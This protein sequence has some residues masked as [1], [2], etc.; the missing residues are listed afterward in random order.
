MEQFAGNYTGP[1]WSN[2]IWQESVEFGDTDPK[3]ELDALS[4][5]HDS[6][7]AK[8][9]DNA[10][11]EAAD[12]IYEKEAKALVGRFPHLAGDLVLHGN[13]TWGQAKDA[14]FYSQLGLPGLIYFAGKNM[15]NA[16]KMIHGTYLQ[17]EQKEILDYFKTD[18][19]KNLQSFG[20]GVATLGKKNSVS[21]PEFVGKKGKIN[22]INVAPK[23]AVPE[24]KTGK[25]GVKMNQVTPEDKI[26]YQ[27]QKANAANIQH[28]KNSRG[29][30]MFQLNKRE[31]HLKGQ[32]GKVRV[33]PYFPEIVPDSKLKLT[34]EERE[35]RN[36][37]RL[38]MHLEVRRRPPP[39]N[40]VEAAMPY[41]HSKRY[42]FDLEYESEFQ[43]R[44]PAFRV[45]YLKG[46]QKRAAE[47]AAIM[48]AYYKKK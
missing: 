19:K 23:P 12:M 40:L 2:G 37:L 43:R 1:N 21:D 30:K 13:R 5:L 16:N 45:G 22:V 48:A 33:K 3:S 39:M 17:K 6:A 38:I 47:D 14:L 9:K 31:S 46:K 24:L 41:K 4:R 20:K 29:F 10:H 44:L 18:P 11:R 36:V 8:Y 42:Q 15:W 32:K 35:V 26:D 34:P 25:F 28:Q 7:Y 27:N